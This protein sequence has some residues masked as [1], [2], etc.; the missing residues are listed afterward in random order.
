MKTAAAAPYL[1]P[2]D[3]AVTAQPWTN[4][5]GVEISERLDHWDPNTDLNLVRVVEI[6][7]DL[8]RE[9]CLLGRDSA[10][11]LTATWSSTTTRIAGHG[12]VVELG[13][14]EGLLRAAMHVEVSGARVGGRLDLNTKLV[15]RYPG[16]EPS[17]ISPKRLGATLWAEED[18][19][20]LEG[21]AAR[22]PIALA[23]FSGTRLYPDGAAWVLEWDSDDL[24]APVLGGMRL[25]VN[26]NHDSLLQTLKTG[27]SDARAAAVRSFVIFDAARSLITGALCNERFVENPEAYAEG[28]VGRMLFELIALC[29]PGIPVAALK[30]RS[31]DESSRFG[32]ELQA[33]FGLIA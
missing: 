14:T 22:F 15:L 13:T 25:L 18:R 30:A 3:G 33:H 17:P 8:I 20:A 12:P 23:D 10:L 19:I 2:P 31:V 16:R 26:K 28:S 9:S 32:A 7:V 29:W 27:S 4:E 6:D 11:A 21:S 5:D 1:L 24:D